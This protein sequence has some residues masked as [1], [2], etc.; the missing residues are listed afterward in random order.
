[1]SIFLILQGAAKQRRKIL[2]GHFYN[3]FGKKTSVIKATIN[4]GI[5]LLAA[6]ISSN[7]QNSRKFD[8]GSGNVSPR[9]QQ[10]IASD[11]YS[12]EKG[13]GFEPGA[14]IQCFDRGGRDPLR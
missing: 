14:T 13:F 2:V 10:V 12:P 3:I 11:T 9:Y 1:M 7:S 4:F 8:F 6:A 5:L